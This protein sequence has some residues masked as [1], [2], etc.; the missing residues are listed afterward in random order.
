M[1]FKKTKHSFIYFQNNRK[2]FDLSSAFNGAIFGYNNV[3]F[4]HRIKNYLN[5][6]PYYLSHPTSKFENNEERHPIYQF[7]PHHFGKSHPFVYSIEKNQLFLTLFNEHSFQYNSLKTRFYPILNGEFSDTYNFIQRATNKN[8][9]TATHPLTNKI[10]FLNHGPIQLASEKWE[11]IPYLMFDLNHLMSYPLGFIL[12]SKVKLDIDSNFN[13]VANQLI[14]DISRYFF[15]K[16]VQIHQKQLNHLV[17]E[18]ISKL[19]QRQKDIVEVVYQY[20]LFLLLR[21]KKTH[22]P[23]PNDRIYYKNISFIIY[24]NL[25]LVGIPINEPIHHLPSKLKEVFEYLREL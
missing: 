14:K 9:K 7:L 1:H 17:D 24:D 16:P 3:Y 12:L 6:Y 10:L 5:R 21:V 2:F 23:L 13:P 25:V 22:Q 4:N 15:S 11:Q 18:E 20:N 19:L 8:Q